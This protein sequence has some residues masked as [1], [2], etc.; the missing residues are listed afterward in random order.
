MKVLVA[1]MHPF[2]IVPRV[3]V[4]AKSLSG[5][6]DLDGRFAPDGGFIFHFEVGKGG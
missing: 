3:L 1:G 2:A 4:M 5:S 6:S